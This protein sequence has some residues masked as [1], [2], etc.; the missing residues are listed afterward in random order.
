MFIC[1]LRQVLIVFDR[2]IF[3]FFFLIFFG[4]VGQKSDVSALMG[5]HQGRP[6]PTCWF[7][8]GPAW[9]VVRRSTGPSPWRWQSQFDYFLNFYIVTMLESGE[10]FFYIYYSDFNLVYCEI[11][12]QSL[13]CNGLLIDFTFL[14][15]QNLWCCNNRLPSVVSFYVIS[16]VNSY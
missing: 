7:L 15:V 3:L 14:P 1:I 2:N 13:T 11:R 6:T 8:H 10:N 9:G 12:I 16:V 4:G 5:L